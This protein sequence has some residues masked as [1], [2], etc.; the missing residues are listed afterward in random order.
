MKKDIVSK[1]SLVVKLDAQT[2]WNS[3]TIID[4]HQS[5]KSERLRS[6]EWRIEALESTVDTMDINN[7]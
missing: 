5:I 6:G 1:E 2:P 3:L 7:Q 4:L